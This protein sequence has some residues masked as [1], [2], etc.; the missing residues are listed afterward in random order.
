[1]E[2]FFC[3]LRQYRGLKSTGFG[4]ADK[5]V[6]FFPFRLTL[7]L[8]EIEGAQ[9]KAKSPKTPVPEGDAEAAP[10]PDKKSVYLF[11]GAAR[12]SSAYQCN[13]SCIPNA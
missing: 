4:V 8:K 2:S 11:I 13:G 6:V 5:A 3:R 7:K 9:Q 10:L 1:M 12:V